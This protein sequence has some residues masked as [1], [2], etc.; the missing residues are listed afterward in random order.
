MRVLRPF[1]PSIAAVSSMLHC[2]KSRVNKEAFFC[3]KC[4]KTDRDNQHDQADSP[5][6]DDAVFHRGVLRAVRTVLHEEDLSG[7]AT[8][9]T[10]RAASEPNPLADVRGRGASASSRT[11]PTSSTPKQMSSS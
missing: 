3:H 6:C 11:G 5:H 2:T 8:P 4:D 1:N 7:A 10:H 9:S